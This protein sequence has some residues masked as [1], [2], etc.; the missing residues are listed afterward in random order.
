MSDYSYS[1]VSDFFCS[2][3][4]VSFCDWTLV[5]YSINWSYQKMCVLPSYANAQPHFKKIDTN[6]PDTTIK[7]DAGGDK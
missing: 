4:S 1:Y 7:D 3:N 6:S 5:D 2:S